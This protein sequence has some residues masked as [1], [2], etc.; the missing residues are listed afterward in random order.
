M[1]GYL[2]S[3]KL[4]IAL[5]NRVRSKKGVNFWLPLGRYSGIR[6]AATLVA[7]KTWDSLQPLPDLF[8]DA[9]SCGRAV[10]LA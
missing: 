1:A 5:K 4:I 7:P 3:P 8:S 9:G 6:N 2:S 10:L